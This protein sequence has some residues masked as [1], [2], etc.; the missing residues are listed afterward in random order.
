MCGGACTSMR[1]R[2]GGAGSLTKRSLVM[3]FVNTPT[4]IRALIQDLVVFYP[5]WEYPSKD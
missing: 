5:E 4:V 2:P 1:N 3:G